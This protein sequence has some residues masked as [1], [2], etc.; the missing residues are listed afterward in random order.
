[1]PVEYERMRDALVRKGMSLK[2]AKGLAARVFN[3]RHPE[4]PNPW[5]KEDKKKTDDRYLSKE[6]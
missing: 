3:S 6:K 5:L 1:M 4:N 2:R